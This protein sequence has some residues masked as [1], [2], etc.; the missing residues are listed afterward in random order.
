MRFLNRLVQTGERRAF[1]LVE[2]LVVIA[3]I[4]VL[5]SLLLPAVQSAREAAR[6]TQCSS[7][8]RQVAIGLHLHHDAQGKLPVAVNGD[9]AVYGTWQVYVLPYLEESQLFKY[10]DFSVGYASDPNITNVTTRRLATLTC[11]SDEP[12]TGFSDITS[13]NYSVNFGNTAVD[14]NPGA[15]YDTRQLQSY[16]GVTFGGAPFGQNEAFGWKDVTDGTSHTLLAAEVVQGQQGDLRGFSWWGHGAIFVGWIGPNS[17]S[18]DV[19]YASQYC[20]DKLPNP[21]CI[22]PGSATNPVM[23]GAR[24]RHPGG[25][26][27]AMC[28]GSVR[29]QSNAIWLDA[30]RAQAS[31]AGSD[32]VSE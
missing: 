29:F 21:P 30:W 14:Y 13:H 12:S 16:N 32:V 9:W 17:S 18:P 10:Y 2:L 6:R 5:V 28:D 23:M 19:I 4:G 20:V 22:A 3:I 25:V 8:L 27:A 1:T 15:G 31:S 26:N 11:T 24:S 7:N